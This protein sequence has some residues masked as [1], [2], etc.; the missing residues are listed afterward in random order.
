PGSRNVISGNGNINGNG[1]VADGV[2]LQN[3]PNNSIQGNYI[4][5]G[6]NS[7]FSTLLLP[8][9]GNGVNIVDSSGAT[10]GG[11]LNDLRNVIS[12]NIR[13]G[14]VMTGS[15]ASGNKVIGNYI[16]VNELGSADV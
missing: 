15:G 13:D 5:L 2:K 10:V 4:G 16:G 8:N 7:N 1:S 11:T 9:T 14:V 3:A 6:L 12:G